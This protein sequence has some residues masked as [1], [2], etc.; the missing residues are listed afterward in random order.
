MDEVVFRRMAAHEA[1]HWWFVG[2][3]AVIRTLLDKL[4]LPANARILEAGC[5]TGGNLYLLSQYGE[6]AAFEPDQVAR[7]FASTTF[8]TGAVTEGS[9]PDRLGA[10]EGNF[11]LVVALDVLEHIEDD[12]NA[13]ATLMHLVK[14]GGFLVVTVPAIRRLWGRHDLRLHHVRRYNLPALRRLFNAQGFEIVSD[15]YFNTLLLPVATLLRL[16]ESVSGGS[17]GDQERMPPGLVNTFLATMFAAERVVVR[18][19]RL[20]IG[21]SAAVIVRRLG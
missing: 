1:R 11:D 20:P 19:W 10:V 6:V 8:P 7:Q 9:L 3:R 4:P 18:R 14:P 16:L 5:G 15:T 2:R 17:I 21:L 13:A 12:V